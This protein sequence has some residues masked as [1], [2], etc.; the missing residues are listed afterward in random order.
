VPDSLVDFYIIHIHISSLDFSSFTSFTGVVLGLF[1]QWSRRER[2][3]VKEVKE[4]SSGVKEE[5]R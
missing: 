2:T 4:G 1:N 5:R 3:G